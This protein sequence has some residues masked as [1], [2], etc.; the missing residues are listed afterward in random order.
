VE[1]TTPLLWEA[2]SLLAL[3]AISSVMG[4]DDYVA[5]LSLLWGQEAVKEGSKT[6]LR[7]E[8]VSFVKSL[9]RLSPLF[10]VFD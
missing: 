8:N 5:K 10:Q 4:Q 1:N 6:E 3:K 9:G 2:E 7:L